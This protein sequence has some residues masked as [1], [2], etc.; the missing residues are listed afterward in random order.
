MNRAAK[1]YSKYAV[2]LALSACALSPFRETQDWNF[3]QSVGGITLGVP[4]NKDGWWSLPVNCDVSGLHEFSRKPTMLNSGMEWVNTI[5]SFKQG[6]IYL[7]IETTIASSLQNWTPGC[8]P[9]SLGRLKAGQYQ[10]YYKDPDGTVH[11]I[12]SIDVKP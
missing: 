6:R 9:A 3:M 12:Q 7:T 5:T 8:G 10:V 1:S 4:Q 11:P 2:L